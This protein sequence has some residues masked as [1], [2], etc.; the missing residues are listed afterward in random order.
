[1]KQEAQNLYYELRKMG[2][3][4]ALALAAVI[5]FVTSEIQSKQAEPYD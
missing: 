2:L 4:H 5:E 1:M 3:S